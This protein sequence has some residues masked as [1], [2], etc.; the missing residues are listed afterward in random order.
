MYGT[1]AGTAVVVLVAAR[2]SSVPAGVTVSLRA[3]RPNVAFVCEPGVLAVMTRA[4]LS[5][6]VQPP[7]V[8]TLPLV[9]PTRM[10]TLARLR[11]FSH[12]G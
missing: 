1:F 7:A 5:L 6:L 3:N 12:L 4:M 9:L 8:L 11:L 2:M 10:R